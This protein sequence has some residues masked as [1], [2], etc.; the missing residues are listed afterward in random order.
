MPNYNADILDKL[1]NNLFSEHEIPLTDNE[2]ELKLIIERVF[3][4]WLNDPFK[5][6][7]DMRA[8]LKREYDFDNQKCYRIMWM[9]KS[10]LGNVKN[11]AKEWQKYKILKALED[12]Y[13]RAKN[14][15]NLIAEIA[16]LEKM[17]KFCKLDKDDDEQMGFDKVFV[18]NWRFVTN[19]QVIGLP[20]IKDLDQLKQK[21]REKYLDNVQDIDFED[22]K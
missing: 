14:Q 7:V 16:A 15:G 2:K 5:T 13:M 11:A 1:E 12:V 18:Q 6:D 17:G 8:F 20:P 19:I 9:V 22:V 10:L 21:M 3:T 4:K